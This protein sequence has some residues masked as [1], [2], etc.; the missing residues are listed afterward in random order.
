MG[1]Q[2][3]E[4]ERAQALL[5]C[6]REKEGFSILQQ[7]APCNPDAGYLLATCLR[8]GIG[9]EQKY[10]KRGY[11]IIVAL[12]HDGYVPA[13][14]DAAIQ[15]RSTFHISGL[16]DV[17]VAI[18]DELSVSLLD[19]V[20]ELEP[21][22]ATALC[23]RGLAH[24][25]GRGCQLDDAVG[26]MLL[27]RAIELGDAEAK[28]WLG[29]R[30]L[31][32]TVPTNPQPQSG[33]LPRPNGNIKRERAMLRGKRLLDE[34]AGVGCGHAC[35]NL[36]RL[37]RDA[38]G[39]PQLRCL[40][41]C[42]MNPDEMKAKSDEFDLLGGQYGAPA[43]YCNVAES[44]STGTGSFP[45]DF[46][47]ASEFYSRAFEDGFV[48]AADAM[49]YHLEKGGE[50]IFPERIDKQRALV[51][52]ERGRSKR[53]C[54]SAL[55]LGEAYDDGIGVA[56]DPAM[57]EK[58]YFEAQCYAIESHSVGVREEAVN[59]LARLYLAQQVIA[60]DQTSE[61]YWREKLET[62]VGLEQSRIR[63]KRVS[64]LLAKISEFDSKS[65]VRRRSRGSTMADP[66]QSSVYINELKE[67]VSQ[68]SAEK[69]V[70]AYACASK[71]DV[72]R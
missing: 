27:E 15:V 17:P 31:F 48:P 50:G 35:I 33:K 49:G 55:H 11:E 54:A 29:G 21:E 19:L 42:E 71:M 16:A 56:E 64:T 3:E 40:L 26:L 60:P 18:N 38:K 59:N 4:L 46:D 62:A 12:A 69:L 28:C 58:L 39:N 65:P 51:W 14:L 25:Y 72:S 9:C 57:A 53:H 66:A 36:A 24:L 13:I 37:Y 30:L 68:G 5:G 41:E 20:L 23:A 1:H 34:S 47:R 10:P 61:T 44:Y 32:L 43:G 52:Y 7:L 6:D 67:L 63:R 45:P 8:Y 70:S 2:A 22:N